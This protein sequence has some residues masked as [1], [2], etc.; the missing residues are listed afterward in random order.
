MDA[1]EYSEEPIAPPPPPVPGGMTAASVPEDASP[2]SPAV[3][4]RRVGA[5]VFGHLSKVPPVPT[6]SD[7]ESANQGDMPGNATESAV[8]EI[9]FEPLHVLDPLCVKWGFGVGVVRTGRER[10]TELPKPPPQQVSPGTPEPVFLNPPPVRMPV[11]P[12]SGAGYMRLMG[13]LSSGQLWEC[14]LP[15]S[16]MCRPGGMVIG[17]D[18]SCSQ[19]VLPE[20]SVSRRHTLVECIDGRVMVTDMGSTNG[21]FVSGRRIAP[22]EQRV[23]VDDGIILTLG[24]VALRVELMPPPLPFSPR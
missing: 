13:L 10:A 18:P 1:H 5:G 4:D 11:S 7:D 20:I 8:P 14:T 2:A 22:H 15:Y 12:N 23:P 3:S 21:T 9:M 24:E 17:R 6:L 16:E 19:V